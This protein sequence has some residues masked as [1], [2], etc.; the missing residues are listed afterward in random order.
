MKVIRYW[1][2]LSVSKRPRNNKSFDTPVKYHSDPLMICKFQFF[3]YVASV[4]KY[5]LVA[6]QTNKPM[7]PFLA[8]A[9][10]QLYRKCLTLFM[11]RDVVNGCPTSFLLKLDLEKEDYQHPL[12]RVDLGSA[13][14]SMLKKSYSLMMLKINPEKNVLCCW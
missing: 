2:A 9:V 6:F 12:G 14:A 1:L 7:L 11:K 13:A 3:K 10:E 5:F 4:L 8:T